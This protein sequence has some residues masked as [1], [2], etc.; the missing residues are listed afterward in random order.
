MYKRGRLFLNCVYTTIFLFHPSLQAATYEYVGSYNVS[1]GAFWQDNPPVYSAQ[2]A[3][4]LVFGGSPGDYAI[5]VE[6]DTSDPS[7]I[8]FTGY[9]SASYVGCII[10]PQDT[11]RDDAPEGYTSPDDS[12]SA[13]SAYVQDH[14]GIPDV[15]YFPIGYPFTNHVWR[16]I[17][18]SEPD[19]DGDGI[20]DASDNCPKTTNPDQADQD[21]DQIGD[22]CDID[23]DG[24]GAN[25]DVDNC[26]VDNNPGQ[27]DTDFDTLGDICDSD[28]DNDGV[29]DSVDNCEL[30]VNAD[31]IDS[32]GDGQGDPCDGDL[33][34][35]GFANDADNCPVYPNSSQNDFDGDGLGDVCDPD[36][37]NDGVTNES[38]I[39]A[40][41][42]YV[43]MVDLYTGCSLDQLC[44]CDGPRGST[45][46][47]LN[48]GKY[49]SCIA[50]TTESFVEMGLITGADKSEIVAAARHSDCR[51]SG[52]IAKHKR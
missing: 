28:D 35:D 48:N 29:D 40:G 7:T 50:K 16:V 4:A 21:E 9:Y 31:Q 8:T 36:A 41:T 23:I 27:D 42:S 6:P 47:W 43:A 19:F 46:S 38:D 10:Y 37:D 32:D 44:P 25:N 51:E 22:S 15:N 33:D 18:E 13:I 2:E 11:R 26:P 12:Y 34:G 39:C 20:I 24:D 49:L 45:E 5:S 17:A 52:H 30:I 14:C 1:D 3:A